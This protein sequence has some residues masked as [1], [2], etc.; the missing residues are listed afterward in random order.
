MELLIFISAEREMVKKHK[1]CIIL[2]IIL[3]QIVTI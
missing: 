1:Y 3:T 2:F